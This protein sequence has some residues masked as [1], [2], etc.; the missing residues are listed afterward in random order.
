MMNQA[1]H[2]YL[3][4][5]HG[6]PGTVFRLDNDGSFHRVMEDVTVPNGMSWSMDDKTFYFTDSPTHNIFAYDFDADSAAFSNKRVFFHAEDGAVPDGHAQDEHGNVWVALH[7]GWKVVRVS[8]E[9]KVTAEVH[10]PTRCP[11][12][13]CSLE[14][15][16][17]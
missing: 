16:E 12:V 17:V 15:C 5:A 1:L 2:D 11:T 13:C 7:G 8:P 6:H 4:P 9:G 14:M 3:A 10:V